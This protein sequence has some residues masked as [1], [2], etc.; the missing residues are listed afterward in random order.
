MMMDESPTDV[1]PAR[2]TNMATGQSSMSNIQVEEMHSPMAIDDDAS[3]SGPSTSTFPMAMGMTKAGPSLLPSRMINFNV[4]YRNT[5][6]P[7]VLPDS[8]TVGQS[9]ISN[10]LVSCHC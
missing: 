9:Q 4:E 7:I 6:I 5:N 8:E 3:A 2:M 10:V 1:G